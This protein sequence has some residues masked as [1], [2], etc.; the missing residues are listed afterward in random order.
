MAL[1]ITGADLVRNFTGMMSAA[2]GLDGNVD[3]GQDASKAKI[4]ASVRRPSV[5]TPKATPKA[6]PKPKKTKDA[7]GGPGM[8]LAMPSDGTVSDMEVVCPLPNKHTGQACNKKCSGVCTPPFTLTS[9][10]ANS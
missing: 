7:S 5:L 1:S 8:G 9:F 2:T 4:K 6:I 3:T 10:S